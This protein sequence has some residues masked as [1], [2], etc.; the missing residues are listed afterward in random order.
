MGYCPTIVTIPI[1]AKLQLFSIFKFLY[2]IKDRKIEKTIIRKLKYQYFDYCLAVGVFFGSDTLIKQLKKT[3]PQLKTILALWD[4][5]A[6]WNF[7]FALDWFDKKYSFDIIDCENYKA[8]GLMYNPDFFL[9]STPPVA[10]NEMLYDL[11]HIGTYHQF[12][13]KRLDIL[14][15][16]KQQA[17]LFGLKYYITLLYYPRGNG[18][19]ARIVHIQAWLLDKKYRDFNKQI[20]EIKE[21]DCNIITNKHLTLEQCT[22]IE[23]HSRCIID[24][25]TD[26]QSGYPIRTINTIAT[27]QK[28]MIAN[29][30]IAQEP[31]Y[32][33]NNIYVIDEILPK[34]DLNFLSTQTQPVNIDYL[35][36]KNWLMRLIEN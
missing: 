3:N 18:I 9:D 22:Y 1:L 10:D 29:K 31:F 15:K 11:C 6:G 16:I 14:L 20:K 34:L 33:E 35:S 2:R 17:D 24:I 25:P 21:S 32:N 13:Q 19:K 12:T 4:S 36:L 30:Y 8:K 28:L 27:G 26:V 5:F 23:K 7:S